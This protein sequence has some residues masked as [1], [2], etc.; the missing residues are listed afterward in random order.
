M[1]WRRVTYSIMIYWPRSRTG[2]AAVVSSEEPRISLFA[3]FAGTLKQWINSSG[4][5]A[6]LLLRGAK[7]IGVAQ[8][9]NARRTYWAMVIGGD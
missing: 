8:A 2:W 9:S 5:P 6:N 4:H 7:W 3:D 1:P